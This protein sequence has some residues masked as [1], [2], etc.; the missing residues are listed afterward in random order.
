[1]VIARTTDDRALR[2]RL[3]AAAREQAL[4]LLER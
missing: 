3:R 1:M 4:A 2:K